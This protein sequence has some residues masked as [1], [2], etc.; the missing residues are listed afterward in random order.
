MSSKQINIGLIGLGTIGVGVAKILTQNK[1]NLALRADIPVVLK[2]AVDLDLSR[3]KS[4]DM[5]GVALSTRAADILEDPEIDI[6]VEVIGGVNPARSFIETALKSGKHVVTSNK[7][8]IAKH[9]LEF[10]EI[11]MEHKVNIYFEAAVGGGIPIIHALKNSLA[12]NNIEKIFGIV[13][14][15]TNYILTK[16]T[17]EGAAFEAVLKEAQALGYAEANPSA[18]VDGYD[19]AYKLSILGSLAFN[20]HFSYEDIF[21]EG[22]RNINATDIRVASDLG[23]VIK[24]LA[25]GVA[26]G[27]DVELRVHPAM[28]EKSHPLANVNGSFNAIF[29]K[30]NYVNETMF[31]GPGAGELP[32]ASAVVGDILDIAMSPDMD[33]AHPSI[34]TNLKD[35]PIRPIGEIVSEYY[36]RIEVADEA[37]V[38]ASI[39]QICGNHKVSIR[40][41]QQ[42]DPVSGN[43]ELVLIT[44]LVKE[45]SMQ[46]ALAEIKALPTVRAVHSLIRV[47]I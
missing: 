2:R 40:A 4:L 21:F 14:G 31:Y 22:I 23:Y 39:A 12:A 20:S 35:K 36:L 38:L 46:A 13:N 24:L 26:H 33:R 16:M 41:V 27:E 8:V 10:V 18:D 43:A 5:T 30:G 44:H 34:A 25:I 37:G 32:T 19:V 47:G 11:A 45:G 15:T 28:I 42:K 1:E 7:E 17:R 6:V 3:V 9:G 29:V